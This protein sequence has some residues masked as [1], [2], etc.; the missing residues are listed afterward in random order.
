[1]KTGKKI[2]TK[3]DIINQMFCQLV[4]VKRNTINTGKINSAEDNPN[5]PTLNALPL[6]FVKYLEI[7]VVAVW[8][9]IPCPE[10]LI[11]K[12]PMN[13]KT[14]E[15]TLEKKKQENERRIATKIA[16]LNTFTSSIFFPTHISNKLLDKV[17][18]A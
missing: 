18:I 1:M 11:K 8:D 15:D 16:N 14:T 12:I 6:D 17:A 9:I 10:N 2:N 4:R 3:S 5:Q 13:K 7:V